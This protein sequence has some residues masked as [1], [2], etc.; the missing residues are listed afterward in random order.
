MNGL[1]ITGTDTGVGK[2]TITAG[3]A[4]LLRSQGRPVRVSKPIATGAHW[5]DRRRPAYTGDAQ[6][7]P[8]DAGSGAKPR[9]TYSR[10]GGERDRTVSGYR[11]R[12]KHRRIAP[13]DGRAA[14]GRRPL[15]RRRSGRPER[16][17]LAAA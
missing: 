4:Q 11:G 14:V 2:T 6:P 10:R 16:G 8:L 3:L 5:V 9:L 1:F 7:H 13:A 17:R 12:N 15:W